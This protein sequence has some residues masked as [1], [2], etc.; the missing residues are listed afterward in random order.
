MAVLSVTEGLVLPVT[1]GGSALAA[2]DVVVVGGRVGI[3]TGPVAANAA[4]SLAIAGVF[5][6]LAK[7]STDEVADGDILYWDAGNARCT[8][9]SSTHKVIG[10]A[11]GAAAAPAA[12]VNVKLR[13][14]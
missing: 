9:T 2:G 14:I 10:Y 6:G 5:S 7:L 11:W 4:Y 13:N 1:N 8:T 3:V 12:V